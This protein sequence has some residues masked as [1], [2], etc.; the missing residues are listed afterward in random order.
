MRSPRRVF[1]LLGCHV[2]ATEIVPHVPRLST[3]DFHFARSIFVTFSATTP[4]GVD[5]LLL[6]IPPTR[7]VAK[8]S[9][10]IG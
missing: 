8:A 1:S 6:P 5:N 3:L 2:Y 7:F 9:S 10:S 4:A